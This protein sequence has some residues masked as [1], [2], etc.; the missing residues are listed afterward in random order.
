MSRTVSIRIDEATERELDQ[1]AARSGSRNAAVVAAI[2]AE[3]RRQAY[4]ALRA[5]GTRL[6]EDPD[7]L[8][9]VAG[10]RAQLGSD[11]AW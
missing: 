1:L 4:Q 10:A 7:Y 2:H 3:Y 9:D 5:T 6:G 8:A 11:D